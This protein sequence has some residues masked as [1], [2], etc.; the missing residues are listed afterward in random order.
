MNI[1]IPFSITSFHNILI[2]RKETNVMVETQVNEV[3]PLQF[4]IGISEITR[5]MLFLIKL[6][7]PPS[8]SL[9]YI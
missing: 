5:L 7:T 9:L 6:N 2:V 8:I 3:V 4:L 1:F